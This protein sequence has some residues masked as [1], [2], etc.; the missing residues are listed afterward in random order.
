MLFNCSLITSTQKKCPLQ[1]HLVFLLFILNAC[2]VPLDWYDDDPWYSWP[3]SDSESNFPRDLNRIGFEF[4]SVSTSSGAQAVGMLIARNS[5]ATKLASCTAFVIEKNLI[6]TNHHC[7][8]AD[9]AYRG[10]DCSGRIAFA[11]PSGERLQCEEIVEIVGSDEQGLTGKVPDVAIFRS[12][13]STN[14]RPIQIGEAYARSEPQ[15][16]FLKIEFDRSIN[17]LTIRGSLV[18]QNCETMKASHLDVGT[19]PD[20]MLFLKNCPVRGGNSG[21]PILESGNSEIAVGILQ[22]GTPDEVDAV[23][24]YY[25]R[26]IA[27]TGKTP[28]HRLAVGTSLHLLNKQNYRY[29][30][31]VALENENR[32]YQ[33]IYRQAFSEHLATDASR[34]A[35]VAARINKLNASYPEFHWHMESIKSNSIYALIPGCHRISDQSAQEFTI[36]EKLEEHE[37]GTRD[38]TEVYV[39]DSKIMEG[40]FRFKRKTVG[41]GLKQELEVYFDQGILHAEE[42]LGTIS[43]GRCP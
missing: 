29:Q 23:K 1:I 26:P 17:D 43:L 6:M 40:T 36:T 21:S 9:I 3:E 24:D 18:E 25:G 8:P 19:L 11:L 12:Q 42:K 37:F 33:R 28:R 31:V 5:D 4:S 2:G 20:L 15:L 41:A 7:I 32:S 10:A 30:G 16:R 35:T 39:R 22:A 27:G 34:K 14:R 13:K 38:S